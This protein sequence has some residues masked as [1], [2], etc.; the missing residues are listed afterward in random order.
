LAVEGGLTTA[1][2]DDSCKE[3]ISGGADEAFRLDAG[4]S[5][6]AGGDGF[7][8]RPNCANATY[9]IAAVAMEMATKYNAFL[10]L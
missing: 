8:T 5:T 9:V 1:G 4:E 6:R 3:P 7:N 2:I 10:F